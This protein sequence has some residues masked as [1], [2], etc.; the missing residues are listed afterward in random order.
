MIEIKIT[1]A[2]SEMIEIGRMLF[3]K[4][5]LFTK[6]QVGV[7]KDI[8]NRFRLTRKCINWSRIKQ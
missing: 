3:R 6:N 1:D 7:V 8:I 5:R 4:R 2:P